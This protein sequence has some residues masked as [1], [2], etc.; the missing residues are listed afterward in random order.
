M[1]VKEQAMEMLADLS[2][3]K[4]ALAVA[5]STASSPAWI[6]YLNGEQFQAI[7]QAAGFILTITILATQFI[8]MPRIIRKIRKEKVDAALKEHHL[9]KAGIDPKTLS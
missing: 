3:G 5:V 9:R 6:T 7:T 4:A 1:P 2:T 8:I